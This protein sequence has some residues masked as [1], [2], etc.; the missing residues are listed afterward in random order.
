MM[1]GTT[2]QM[3]IHAPLTAPTSHLPVSETPQ[4]GE[5]TDVEAPTTIPVCER[6]SLNRPPS[7]AIDE[8]SDMLKRATNMSLG[9][10]TSRLEQW[11]HEQRRLSAGSEAALQG[12]DDVQAVR[13]T[14]HPCV[15]Y[16]HLGVASFR[17]HAPDDRAMVE[18]YIFVDDTDVPRAPPAPDASVFQTLA[19]FSDA[20]PR[21]SPPSTPRKTSP[22]RPSDGFFTLRSH[23]RGYG[24][25]RAS[26]LSGLEHSSLSIVAHRLRTELGATHVSSGAHS[27]SPNALSLHDRPPSEDVQS[28]SSRPM[29]LSPWKLRRPGVIDHFT[30][31][32]DERSH[33]PPSRPSLSSCITQ[34]STASCATISS[35]AASVSRKLYLGSVHHHSPA[36][37]SSSSHSLWS[38]PT[39][40]SHMYDPPESTKVIAQDR[41]K[42]N[43]IRIPLP[44]KM[45]GAGLGSVSSALGSP[46]RARRKRKLIIS[47]IPADDE[48]RYSAAKKWC[49]SFGD[50][51]YF[52]RTPS[53][54]I[55][56]DFRKTEVAETVCRLQARVYIKGVGSVCLSYFT[57]KRP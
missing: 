40:A 37:F 3:T 46:G 13:E 27:S 19:G 52:E 39:D 7:S 18:S 49:E 21:P 29:S 44:L 56:V 51:N 14:D 55:H 57:G 6:T 54:D 41:E 32:Y 36:L 25:R 5:Q 11:L 34:S 38:L 17:T 50:L 31:A 33:L 22:V 1:N 48:R 12:A 2:Y 43:A 10:R 8:K 35:D 30:E 4:E 47:G 24:S 23:R 53:G 20:T 28:Q 42:A 26:T 9:R 16:P 15:A 45:H